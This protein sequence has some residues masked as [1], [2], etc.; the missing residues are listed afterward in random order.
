MLRLQAVALLLMSAIAVACGGP[1]T[2]ETAV[3]TV[4]P[5]DTPTAFP[6]VAPTPTPDQILATSTPARPA[7]QAPTPLITPATAT[8]EFTQF[9]VYPSISGIQPNEALPG[10][11]IKVQGSGGLI[12][13]RKPD[14]SVTG[15]IESAKSFELFLD[16]QA[17][18]SI[19]CYVNVCDGSFV[20]PVATQQGDH[21]ISVEGGSTQILVMVAPTATPPP[22]PTPVPAATPTPVPTATPTPVPTATPT[23]VPTATP[24]PVPMPT[25]TPVP[26]VLTTPAFPPGGGIPLIYTCD[27][28]DTSPALSWTLPP[29]GT[30][31]F[32]IVMDDPD[33]PAGVWDHW[34]VFNLPPDVL[35]LPE[36]QAKVSQ[37]AGGA[38]Q[39]RNSWG[40]YG[41]GGP[42]PPQG[43]P[44]TYRFFVYAVDRSLTLPANATKQQLL[45][46]LEG[47]ILAESAL[48]ATYQRMKEDD[49]GD[50]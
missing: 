4:T 24:T 17:V 3:A 41:Y 33:V 13:L 42:C 9:T 47:H 19:Q 39:G 48:T 35:A 22:T 11:E 34:V 37:L 8:P 44:H 18:G 49:G 46:A 1:V 43:P 7:T 21:E 36:G 31:T 12:E 27:G 32:A 2:N 50:Y 45:A 30:Q 14:G 16:G 26:F 25:P 15:Y 20:L 29:A 28:E 10:Q 40:K 23:P 5:A 6:E 38:V